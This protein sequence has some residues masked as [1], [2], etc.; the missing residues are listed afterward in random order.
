MYQLREERR[1]ELEKY[2]ESVNAL[3][4]KSDR[5]SSSDG[6]SEISANKSWDGIQDDVP[7]E[8]IDHETEYYDEDRFTT[9]TI[10][11][12]AVSKEGLFKI[13]GQGD[14][15]EYEVKGKGV[16][17]S[18]MIEEWTSGKVRSKKPKFRYESKAER[19][20]SR[21]KQKATKKARASTRRGN[22]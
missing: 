4:K 5:S 19:K 3:H 6:D 17:G 7:A 2:I 20:A 22:G 21:I 13:E 10:E 11:E 18:N 9:V 15:V 12:V 8:Q 1:N 16:D 14:E